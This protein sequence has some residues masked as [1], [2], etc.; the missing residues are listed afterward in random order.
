MRRIIRGRETLSKNRVGRFCV[1]I[2]DELM[3]TRW[4]FYFPTTWSPLQST[5]HDLIRND[6]I[7]TLHQPYPSRC[8][9]LLLLLLLRLILLHHDNLISKLLCFNFQDRFFWVRK[10]RRRRRRCRHHHHRYYYYRASVIY[11]PYLH[12]AAMALNSCPVA[13]FKM[14]SIL[15][16]FLGFP[17]FG[18]GFVN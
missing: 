12:K 18:G 11:S 8:S 10:H 17:G 14:S 2:K 7:A 13:Q 9:V 1:P 4:S 5:G 15:K 16:L 3:P 6:L